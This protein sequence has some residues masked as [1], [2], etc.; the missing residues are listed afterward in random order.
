MAN[1]KT[2]SRDEALAEAK[3]KGLSGASQSAFVNIATGNESA[4]AGITD[5]SVLNSAASAFRQFESGGGRTEPTRIAPSVAERGMR[6]DE[7]SEEVDQN[8]LI[9]EEAANK[10]QADFANSVG[11]VDA[12]PVKTT[13]DEAAA[14]T[15]VDTLSQIRGVFKIVNNKQSLY[16]GEELS[17]EIVR[18]F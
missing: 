13:G 12:P 3:N 18:T 16:D 15:V 5:K 4:N 1:E 11:D 2:F 14:P 10:D 9:I 7:I 6:A 8:A 17:G